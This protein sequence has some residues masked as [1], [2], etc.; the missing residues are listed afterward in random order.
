EAATLSRVPEQ[1]KAVKAPAPEPSDAV[2]Q[3]PVYDTRW[4]EQLKA[5]PPASSGIEALSPNIMSSG[6]VRLESSHEPG[7]SEDA[8]GGE[9]SVEADSSRL[10]E[11]LRYPVGAAAATPEPFQVEV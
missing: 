2:R 6:S 3:A 10:L 8:G 4:S 7:V 9:T 11:S 5:R 1:L